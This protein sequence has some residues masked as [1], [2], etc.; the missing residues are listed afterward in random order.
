MLGDILCCRAARDP[1]ASIVAADRTLADESR[2]RF[3][4]ALALFGCFFAD[5]VCADT[6][7]ETYG[8][9]SSWT[10]NGVPAGL[11]ACLT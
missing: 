8:E 5:R 9:P 10:G 2:R 3:V 6:G 7:G 1:E 11:A 4:L